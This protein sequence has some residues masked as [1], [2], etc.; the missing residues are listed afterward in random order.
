[1]R[2]RNTR[3]VTVSEASE[4]VTKRTKAFTQL[5]TRMRI[6]C[7]FTVQIETLKAKYM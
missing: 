5:R 2:H 4:T 7:V 3:F 6:R 1:M